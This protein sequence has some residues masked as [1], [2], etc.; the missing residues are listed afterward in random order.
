MSEKQFYI[1]LKPFKE[2]YFDTYKEELSKRKVDVNINYCIQN[3][4]QLLL[5]TLFS[6]KA[7]LT[8]DVLGIVCG[9]NASNAKRNQKIGL[10]ILKK[11]L[12]QLNHMPVR[13]ILNNKDF[14]KL[15]KDETDLILDITEQRIQ[16]PSDD[17]TQKEHYSGKKKPTH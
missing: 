7:G 6:L 13:N 12:K 1:L 4:E 8:Y 14:N 2:A 11:S 10:D 17:E 5:F 9:M 16:R 3:E 15:F